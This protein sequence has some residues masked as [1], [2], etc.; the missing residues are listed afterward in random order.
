MESVDYTETDYRRDMEGDEKYN[1][2]ESF[3]GFQHKEF[4]SQSG[5]LVDS[6]DDVYVEDDYDDAYDD[7]DDSYEE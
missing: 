5:D 7:A 1:N 2:K 3:E 4:D 6:E